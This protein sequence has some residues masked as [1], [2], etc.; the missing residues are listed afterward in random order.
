VV[1]GNGNTLYCTS[2][3]GDVTCSQNI[4]T[5]INIISQ[6]GGATVTCSGNASAGSAGY[7]VCTVH[8]ATPEQKPADKPA[9]APAKAAAPAKAV[10]PASHRSASAQPSGELAYT[11]A[12]VSFPL[13][14]GL[15]ALGAGGALTLAGRRRETATV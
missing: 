7:G 9:V 12:D 4:T 14:L 2:A 6:A 5:I 13:T 3:T 1:A 8:H 11:G 15:L 10:A